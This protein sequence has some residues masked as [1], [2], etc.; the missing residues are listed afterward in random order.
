VL[1]F[2][3]GIE[4]DIVVEPIGWQQHDPGGVEARLP[5]AVGMRILLRPEA[6]FAIGADLETGERRWGTPKRSLLGGSGDSSAV[7]SLAPR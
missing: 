5:F 1:E 3:P 7:V 2:N 6:E 4:N